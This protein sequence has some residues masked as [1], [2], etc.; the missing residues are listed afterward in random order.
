MRR[1]LAALLST[2]VMAAAAPAAATTVS[3]LSLDDM[4]RQATHVVA[5]DVVGEEA[6]WTG[7]LLVTRVTLRVSECLKGACNDTE[8]R[9]NVLGG[10]ADG[11]VMVVEGAPTFAVGERVVLFLQPAAGGVLRTVGMAQGKFTFAAAR[12]DG[13]PLSRDLSG[14]TLHSGAVAAPHRHDPF[15]GLTFIDL[16]DVVRGASDVAAGRIRASADA[17]IH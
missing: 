5:G 6:A 15:E 4:A 8:I 7:N 14:L 17:A 1:T 2:A 13:E 9:I 16:R 3:L 10:E 11:L 12:S